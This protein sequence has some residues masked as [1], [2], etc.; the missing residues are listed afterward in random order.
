MS[1]SV[2]NFLIR[3]MST[4]TNIS[5]KVITSVVD[6]QFNS[7]VENMSTCNS[8]E[9]SG[10]G[11]FV[12]NK[13]KGVNMMLKYIREKEQLMITLD[14]CIEERVRKRAEIRISQIEI[15]IRALNQKLQSYENQFCTSVG[16]LEESHNSSS[17]DEGTN[18]STSC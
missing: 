16:R 14:T 7:L 15:S 18:K 5:E 12:F 13:K 4:A 2:K 11:K 9:I 1:L 8:L 6:H 3:K 10:F 17:R